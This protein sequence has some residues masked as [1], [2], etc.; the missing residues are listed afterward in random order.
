[1]G[2]VT[3][4]PTLLDSAVDLLAARAGLQGVGVFSA[5]PGP[6]APPEHIILALEPVAL[7]WERQTAPK[8]Q[9]FESYEVPCL[10]FAKVSGKGTDEELIRNA[11]A[12][13]F[14]LMEEVIDQFDASGTGGV[15]S[16]AALGVRSAKVTVGRLEQGIDASDP[17]YRIAAVPFTLTVMAEFTPASA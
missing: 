6:S 2:A 8:H 11:R 14:E 5:H 3:T 15:N 4:L 1:M 9:V 16:Y 17:A 12:R 7:T 10:A 13:V